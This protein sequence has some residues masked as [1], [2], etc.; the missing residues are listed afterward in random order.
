MPDYF[1]SGVSHFIGISLT[2]FAHNE[3][4]LQNRSLLNP[5]STSG[6]FGSGTYPAS[7]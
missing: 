1:L 2:C 6:P 3:I 7:T 4:L 5:D